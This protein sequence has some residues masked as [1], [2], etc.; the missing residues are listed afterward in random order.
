MFIINYIKFY[1]R[2]DRDRLSRVI[3]TTKVKK[4]QSNDRE[5]NK[6]L[7]NKNYDKT[8]K[9]RQK[10]RE[11]FKTENKDKDKNKIKTFLTERNNLNLKKQIDVD[12]ENYYQSNDMTYFD[13]NYDEQKEFEI[14]VHIATS[15]K[16]QC[17]QCKISFLFNNR[18]HQHLR[19]IEC[20]RNFHIINKQDYFKTVLLTN[21]VENNIVSIIELR[22][23][24]NK[25]VN[26]EKDF[27][28]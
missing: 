3:V 11:N 12:F 24:V 19:V 7:R 1:S 22:I 5:F 14:S 18:L 9:H 25:N 20:D 2:N 17:R 13:S 21:N 10:F 26:F 4:E 28:N 6:N 23:D 15:S 8:D 27:K 16:I